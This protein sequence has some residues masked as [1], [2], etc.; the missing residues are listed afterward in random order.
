MEANKPK[1][2]SFDYCSQ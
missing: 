1:R 2:R